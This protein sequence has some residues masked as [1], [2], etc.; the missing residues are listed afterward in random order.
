MGA[1]SDLKKTAQHWSE[2]TS[3]FSGRNVGMFWWDAGPEIYNRINRKISGN[4][5]CDYTTYTLHT[6]FNQRLP[7]TNCLSLGCG[8]GTL[9]RSLAHQNAF[10]HCDAYDIAEG[11]VEEAKRLAKIDGFKNINYHI[12]DINKLIL[13]ANHYSAVWIQG[14]MHHFEALEHICDQIKHALKPDGLL[15]LHEYVG[16]S[17]F[18][19]SARQKEIANLCLQLLPKEYR[20]IKQEVAEIELARSSSNKSIGWIVS[21]LVDKFRDGDLLATLQRRFRAYTGKV[22]GN[23]QKP[24]ITF[25]SVRDVI[26]SDPTEAIRSD[27]IIAV[28]QQQFDIVEMKELGGNIL[29][30]LL[31]DIA[32]NFANGNDQKSQALLRMLVDIEETLLFCGEFKSDFA[33]VVAQ[34]K[35]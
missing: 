4:P 16:S 20:S 22:S 12:A 31:A 18:Q 19:F 27:E 29:Q 14:A 1:N 30:F 21:R 28:L 7:M 2:H 10:Q 5:D 24:T 26:A 15:I 33:F 8:A 32:G 9:E 23:I 35:R 13:P 25:P 3:I 34:P 11:S 6:Y 17:R